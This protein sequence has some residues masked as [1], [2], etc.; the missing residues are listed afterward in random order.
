MN[1]YSL[2]IRQKDY[3]FL[4]YAIE[5]PIDYLFAIHISLHFDIDVQKQLP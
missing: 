2:P 5:T 3:N 4:V 1:A